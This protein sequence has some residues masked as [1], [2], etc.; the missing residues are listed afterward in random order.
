[1]FAMPSC[2]HIYDDAGKKVTI[3]S[4]LNDKMK[5]TW[6]VAIFNELGRLAQGVED[7][8]TATNNNSFIPKN[9]V[10]SNKKVSCANFICDYRPLKSEPHQVRLTVG[11]NKLECEYY[12]G[13][14]ES[15]GKQDTFNA[16]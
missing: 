11:G 16:D 5:N 14:P 15:N 10:P 4:L 13:S 12:A 9:Q 1:M 7:C 6:S 3:N 8:V 2:N